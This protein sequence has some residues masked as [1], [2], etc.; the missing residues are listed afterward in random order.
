MNHRAQN[1]LPPPGQIPVIGQQQQRA[2]AAVQQGIAQLS[3]SIYSRA[4]LDLI[5]S[6][7]LD[8]NALRELAKRSVAA[9]RAYYEGIGA[10]ETDDKAAD[11]GNSSAP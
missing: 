2:V 9:A 4:A 3:L 6:N 5:D 8:T 1:P 7:T 11:K 10:I